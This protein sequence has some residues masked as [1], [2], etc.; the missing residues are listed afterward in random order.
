MKKVLIVFLLLFGLIPVYAD[1]TENGRLS[2]ALDSYKSGNYENS[3]KEYEIIILNGFSNPYV[4]YNLSNAYYKSND[5]GRASLN[6]EKALRLAPRD[7]DIRYNR[8]FIAKLSGEPEKNTAEYIVNIIELLF[9]LN[10][11]IIAFFIITVFLCVSGGLYFLKQ[12]KLFLKISTVCFIIFS[13]NASL[14]YLKVYNEII[15]C[16]A[17]VLSDT[18][19]RN[20]PIKSEDGA[21]AVS[22]GRKVIILSELGRWVNIKLSVDG[23]SG[24]IDKNYIEKI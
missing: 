12:K 22:A 8:N 11:L 6:I 9:S 3:I 1:I 19:V 16:E 4:Y 15:L 24:W 21:F 13:L 14:L 18:Q 7:G 5:I 23:F 10:E 17:V 20:K 2:A